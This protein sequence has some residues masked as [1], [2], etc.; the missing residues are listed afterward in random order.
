MTRD[1]LAEKLDYLDP[2]ASLALDR[3]L[4]AQMFGAELLTDALTSEIEAFAERHR[5]TFAQQGHDEEHPEFVKNDV[6]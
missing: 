1:E 4:L 2:G 6:F 3:R 5:C